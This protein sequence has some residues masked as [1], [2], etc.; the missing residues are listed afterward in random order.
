[1]NRIGTAVARR[2]RVTALAVVTAA[3]AT[4]L[5][6]AVSSGPGNATTT[7]STQATGTV[8]ADAA[9]FV[10]TGTDARPLPGRLPAD[11]RDDLRH[12]RTLDP[13]RRPEAAARIWRDALTGDYGT[14]VQVRAR[15]AQR[16]YLALPQQLRDDLG[17]L[18]G[19]TPE[20]RHAGLLTI[21]DKALAGTYGDQV[22]RRAERR[23]DFWQHD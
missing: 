10:L 4:G 12:L 11:L 3:A 21:R 17:Q 6:W 19:L 7:V 1:M 9:S 5:V 18:R 23:S 22:Q 8:D 2:T 15:E 16:R 14:S 13:G 20:K